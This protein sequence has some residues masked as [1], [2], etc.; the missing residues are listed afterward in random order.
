M[1]PGPVLQMRVVGAPAECIGRL[2]RRLA[3]MHAPAPP[4]DRERPGACALAPLESGSRSRRQPRMRRHASLVLD[5]SGFEGRQIYL[6][7]RKILIYW[8]DLRN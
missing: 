5:F 3:A 2:L 4:L 6:W 1:E 8:M 7:L